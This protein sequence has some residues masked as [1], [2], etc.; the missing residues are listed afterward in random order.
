MLRWIFSAVAALVLVM[1]LY[2]ATGSWEA[3]VGFLVLIG[4]FIV[5]QLRPVKPSGHYCRHCG[6][7][8]DRNARQ[9]EACGGASW[10]VRD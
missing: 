3:C 2:G 10:S 7:V 8:L 9:C 5:Y 4:G 1:M 6:A